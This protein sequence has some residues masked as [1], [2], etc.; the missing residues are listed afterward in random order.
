[1]LNVRP[2]ATVKAV[3][4]SSSAKSGEGAGNIKSVTAESK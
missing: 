1:M 3:P 2:G 4:L